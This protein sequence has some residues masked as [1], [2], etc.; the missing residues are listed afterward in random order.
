MVGSETVY[1]DIL[2]VDKYGAVIDSIEQLAGT[3]IRAL[4]TDT[5]NRE[6][7]AIKWGREVCRSHSYEQQAMRWLEVVSE[8]RTD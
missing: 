1:G 6:M 3:L 5:N 4:T 8:S 2:G 7:V